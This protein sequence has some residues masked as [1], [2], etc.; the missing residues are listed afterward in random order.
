[1]KKVSLF[2]KMKLYFE[3]RKVLIKNKAE[4]EEKFN[5]RIDG[6]SRIYTVLNIPTDL[7][8]EPYNVR[9]QD[10]DNLSKQ[11]IRKYSQEISKYLDSIGAIELYDFYQIEKVDK[12]SYLVVFGFSLFNTDK[13]ARKLLF[14]YLPMLIIT[15]IIL[16]ILFFI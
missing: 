5:A 12:Y 10:I 14:R 8:E 4:L 6:V 2:K 1:M 13:F 7:I 3:F 9:K 15:F 16:Y 11:F